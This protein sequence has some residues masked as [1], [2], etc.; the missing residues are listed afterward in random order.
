MSDENAADRR[1]DDA[2]DALAELAALHGLTRHLAA[3]LLGD[4]RIPE[5][6]RALEVAVG[7]IDIDDVIERQLQTGLGVVVSTVHP[8]E[9]LDPAVVRIRV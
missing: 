2:V 5:H 6:V 8:A 9:I 7:I 3:E 1:R 4:T